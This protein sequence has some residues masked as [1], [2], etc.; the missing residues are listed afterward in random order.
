MAEETTCEICEKT[1][2]TF[3]ET[4]PRARSTPEVLSSSCTK[5]TRLWMF[6]LLVRSCIRPLA[7]LKMGLSGEYARK[8]STIFEAKPRKAFQQLCTNCRPRC[9]RPCEPESTCT[10]WSRPDALASCPAAWPA[11]CA[12]CET[13]PP[14]PAGEPKE[15]SRRRAGAAAS[16]SVAFAGAAKWKLGG[17]LPRLRAA[18]SS[19]SSASPA[20]AGAAKWKSKLRRTPSKSASPAPSPEVM[21]AGSSGSC[22]KAAGSSAAEL[23]TVSS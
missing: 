22:G 11:Y 16:A 13:R 14:R 23:S 1:L 5:T 8:I 12:A 9:M 15:K 18:P 4:A 2:I 3:C 7:E 10:T 19:G 21:L 17:P 20:A 6:T